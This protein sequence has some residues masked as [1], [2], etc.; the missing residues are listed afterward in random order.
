MTEQEKA[1]Y[2]AGLHRAAQ[3]AAAEGEKVDGLNADRYW[4]SR[5]IGA[6]ILAE[7]ETSPSS[8]PQEGTDQ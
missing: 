4:Q 1:A 2:R 5:R 8:A 3:I 7:T 6:A